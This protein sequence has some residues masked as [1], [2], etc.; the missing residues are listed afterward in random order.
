MRATISSLIMLAFSLASAQ[1]PVIPL[2]QNPSAAIPGSAVFNDVAEVWHANF[3]GS[4]YP[5]VINSVSD[6][7]ATF[8]GSQTYTTNGIH[9]DGINFVTCGTTGGLGNGNT[10][11][12][13]EAGAGVSFTWA[14][15][16][17][18]PASCSG[19]IVVKW[20]AA[21][22]HD[23]AFV[24]NAQSLYFFARNLA[25]NANP[26]VQFSNNVVQ[27]STWH[28]CVFGYDDVNKYLFASL[29]GGTTN[30]IGCVGVHNDSA[31]GLTWGN[32]AD[33][34]STGSWRGSLDEPMIWRRTLSSDEIAYLFNLGA[35][36][37]YPVG[38][39][40]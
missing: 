24:E 16:V 35:G 34:G 37:F 38:T 15:W 17:N 4:V 9:G 31:V 3:N 22:S 21:S 11:T 23:Y 28:F 33:S 25:D 10:G 30:V 39:P 19:A 2:Y 26:Q 6:N 5:A 32:Y 1:L 27:L 20:K 40:F 8:G 12:P 18:L 14:C 29:N 13:W 36:R 7:M